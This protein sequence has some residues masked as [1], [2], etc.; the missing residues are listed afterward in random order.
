M[1][2]LHSCCPDAHVWLHRLCEQ[3]LTCHVTSTC[4]GSRHILAAKEATMH[5]GCVEL[6]P[7][8]LHQQGRALPPI[9]RPPG[10]TQIRLGMK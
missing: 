2:K 8:Y 6:W 4:Q 3:S 1:E 7:N 5:A 10:Q 9:V